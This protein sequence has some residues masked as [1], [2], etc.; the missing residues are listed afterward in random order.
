V[1]KQTRSPKIQSVARLAC[2]ALVPGGFGIA[3]A[4]QAA[5]P[6]LRIISP[7]NGAVVRPGQRSMVRVDGSGDYGAVLVSGEAGLLVEIIPPMGK[8]PWVVSGEIPLDTELGKTEFTATGT[9]LSGAQVQSDPIEIDV[10]PAE[11]PPVTFTPSA[12]IIPVGSCV[13]LSNETRAQ[14]FGDF[15][16]TGTYADGTRVNLN[17]STRINF[18]SQSPAIASMNRDGTVLLGVSPGSTKI[19][20]FGKY[21]IDVTVR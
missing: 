13:R 15:F 3:P 14:C 18:T 6:F 19:V 10:E 12:L 7:A 16:V 2:I 17:H 5:K 1:V 4:Q 20:A 21:T 11:I 8:P 9:T